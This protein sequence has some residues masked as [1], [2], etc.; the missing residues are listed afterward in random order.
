ISPAGV[1][2]K[3][4]NTMSDANVA[5]MIANTGALS[6]GTRTLDANPL[7]SITGS[8]PSVAGNQILAPYTLI[9]QRIGEYPFVCVPNE[10]FVIQGTVPATGTWAFSVTSLWEEV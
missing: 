10:G 6:P 8:V 3:L 7:A 5:V 9:D 2:N 1:S 4:R